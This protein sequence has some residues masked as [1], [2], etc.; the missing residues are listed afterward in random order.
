MLMAFLDRV[1]MR[2]IS[3][4]IMANVLVDVSGGDDCGGPVFDG[5]LFVLCS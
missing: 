1:F 5:Y 2:S 4:K 3:I